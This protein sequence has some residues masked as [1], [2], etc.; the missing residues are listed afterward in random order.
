M[1]FP[2]LSSLG[3]LF[4][5]ATHGSA[6]TRLT[7]DGARDF[8]PSWSPVVSL[9]SDPEPSARCPD[10]DAEIAQVGQRD[11]GFLRDRPNRE[12]RFFPANIF[13]DETTKIVSNQDDDYPVQLY[14]DGTH[15]DDVAGDG[16][17]SAGC[18]TIFDGNLARNWDTTL[19]INGAPLEYD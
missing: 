11:L 2:L 14:D 4:A 3:V 13:G 7:Y 18:L 9:A 6:Q 1:R 10:S 15:G 12:L 19:S 16:L 17:F 5:L 8:A